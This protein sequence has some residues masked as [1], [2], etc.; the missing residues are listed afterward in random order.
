MAELSTST[1]EY[2]KAINYYKEALTYD[3]THKT[4]CINDTHTVCSFE[5]VFNWYMKYHH[6]R[7]IKEKT[8]FCDENCLLPQVYQRDFLML[9]SE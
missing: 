4:V 9:I 6:T 5:Y 2:D 1:R 7:R 8:P 3:D